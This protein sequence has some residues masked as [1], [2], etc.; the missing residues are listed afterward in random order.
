MYVLLNIFIKVAALEKRNYYLGDSCGRMR[1]VFIVHSVYILNVEPCAWITY[2]KIFKIHDLLKL[3]NIFPLLLGYDLKFYCNPAWSVLQQI[4]QPPC[5]SIFTSCMSVTLDFINT[6]VHAL[7]LPA[8]WLLHTTLGF[9]F[10]LLLPL[11][12]SIIYPLSFPD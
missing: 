4:L 2:S 11:I 5:K 9:V 3:F 1:F 12:N 7:L 10:F 6:F 8:S